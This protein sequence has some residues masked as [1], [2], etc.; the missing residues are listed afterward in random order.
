MNMTLPAHTLQRMG[1]E[2]PYVPARR[3]ARA[4]NP[5]RVPWVPVE[6]P[7]LAA[8]TLRGESFVW[9]DKPRILIADS[10]PASPI[11]ARIMAQECLIH[12]VPSPA[13][14]PETARQADRRP[15][16]IL[17]DVMAP[18]REGLEVCRQLKADDMTQSIP[19]ILITDRDNAEDEAC[20][21]LLGA[22]ECIIRPF[23]L[24]VVEARIRNQIRVKRRND[25]LER[26]ANQDSLTDV[27]NRR[28]FDL[29]LDSEWRRGHRDMQPL[30]LVMVDID[31]F[32][33]YNDLYGHR[34][35]DHCLRQVAKAMGRALT[36]PG[37][38]LARYGGEEFAAILPNT[39]LE[40]ARLMGEQLR[41]AVMALNIP[42]QRPDSARQVT[43]SVGC[44]S[45]R[46]SANLT[47][48][49]LLQA[50]DDRLYLAKHSGRNCVR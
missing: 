35:G 33:Q 15:D 38:L 30:S 9:P 26:C 28:F 3:A 13:Q 17:L 12:T 16:L 47:C 22:E 49:S 24:D 46:P 50:A 37:D 43:I 21:L 32:K 10:G 7:S 8:D 44:A 5:L 25:M 4:E 40:G 6:M 42:Q 19:L 39:D 45:M 1:A 48:H 27:A 2:K 36:R 34:E 23:R 31:C 11:L 29:T 14:I 20:A 18:G 41:R